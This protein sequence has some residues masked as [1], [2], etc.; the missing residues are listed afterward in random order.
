[1][2]PYIDSTGNRV[3]MKMISTARRSAEAKDYRGFRRATGL[4]RRRMHLAKEWDQYRMFDSK[5]VL[6][7]VTSSGRIINVDMIRER[8]M[9]GKNGKRGS[10]DR[11]VPRSTERVERC[12]SAK[13][14][15]EY[16]LFQ[17]TNRNEKLLTLEKGEV[18][19]T[20]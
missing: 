2:R 17:K 3:S 18:E 16:Q 15:S 5:V 13:Q 8:R 12:R 1:M 14:W 20:H 10:D 4:A 11:V 19:T 9:Q 6:P 7:F